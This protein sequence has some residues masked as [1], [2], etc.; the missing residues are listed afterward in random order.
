MIEAEAEWGSGNSV[1]E[2]HIMH[3]AYFFMTFSNI[4]VVESSNT[5]LACC[6]LLIIRGRGPPYFREVFNKI[7]T[8]R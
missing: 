5:A 2:T 3:M 7:L 4:V 8:C 6:C 1:N